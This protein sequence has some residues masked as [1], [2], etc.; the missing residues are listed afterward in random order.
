MRI[1]VDAMGSDLGPRTIVRG[2]VDAL[3]STNDTSIVLVGR[4][5]LL[6]KEIDKLH[7][8]A[9]ILSHIE[10]ENAE[11]VIE[12]HEPLSSLRGKRDSS[13]AKAVGLLKGKRADALVAV[14]NTSV[15]VGATK[16]AL[17][18]IEGVR[19]AG[20]AVPM[21]SKQ[22]VTI[23]I[24]MGANITSRPEDL[25][26]YGIMASIYCEDV[27]GTEHPRVGLLNVGEEQEKGN[28]MLK[29]AY[30]LLDRAP[31]NF[32]G[33]V[34]GSDFFSGKCDIVVCDGFV[35]NVVLKASEAV[36]EFTGH[37]LREGLRRNIIAK[38]GA[39]LSKS[40]F[41]F[42]KKRTDY[43]EYG[44]APLLGVKGVC[45]IGHGKSNAQAIMNAI[46]KAKGSVLKRVNE[47]ITDLCI[48]T[49]LRASSVSA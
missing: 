14:G 18:T 48:K 13:I 12:M 40:G 8:S 15:A 29:T 25:A 3:K 32:I 6:T 24:D 46:L 45:I 27:I 28:G 35:G 2:A 30:G 42:F 10:I 26:T 20:I 43:A 1:A 5:E 41:K 49:S 9:S 36:A 4:K 39:W 11:D 16:F 17:S 38:I 44:G 7:P 33:N 19:R 21:P 37:L 31:I 22:G 23:A 34:E 47:K